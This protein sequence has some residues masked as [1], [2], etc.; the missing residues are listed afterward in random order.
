[1]TPLHLAAA[2]GWPEAVRLL[3]AAGSN[4]FAV[5]AERGFPLDYALQ[6]KCW[7]AAEL[8]LEGECLSY[9]TRPQ[10]PI[11]MEMISAGSDT[12]Q[13]ACISALCHSQLSQ[14][15]VQAYHQFA[16]LRYERNLIRFAERL[17][18]AGY[19]DLELRDEFGM[20]AL[21]RAS[22]CRNSHMIKFLMDKGARISPPLGTTGLAAG[23]LLFSHLLFAKWHREARDDEA[24]AILLQA[25]FDITTPV[26]SCCL[27]SP[28]G[29]T[30]I[31]ALIRQHWYD[32]RS[33]R[34]EFEGLISI[35]R[36]PNPLVEKY[37]RIY[38]L[39]EVFNGLEMTHTCIRPGRL[40][41]CIPDEDRLEIESEEEELHEQLQGLMEFYDQERAIFDGAPLDF[42]D[43]FLRLDELALPSFEDKFYLSYE[44][45]TNIIG[46][47]MNY[48]TCRYS[49]Y[50]ERI[51][52]G[53]KEIVTEENILAL[54][55]AKD[56]LLI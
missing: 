25:A 48:R 54:L 53:H 36:W 24:C 55:F 14:S 16:P 40:S 37:V 20:T 10:F 27:C 45:N 21:M 23:H 39:G 46:P 18:L 38:A 19:T 22:Q 50:G 6:C 43:T 44:R 31:T 4:K 52:C 34:R 8:L 41:A 30:P 9:F 3:L 51:W 29:F 28:E 13:T 42:L 26:Q 1:M 7:D 33:T 56:H 15:E 35:L 49:F 17:F 11:M 5:D 2:V 12:L 47:G 32:T